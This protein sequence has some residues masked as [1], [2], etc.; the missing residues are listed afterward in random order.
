MPVIT[1]ASEAARLTETT[2]VRLEAR[3]NGTTLDEARHALAAKRQE[4]TNSPHPLRALRAALDDS[5]N[6]PLPPTA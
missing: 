1:Q 4:I 3:V 2:L 6:G 5:D